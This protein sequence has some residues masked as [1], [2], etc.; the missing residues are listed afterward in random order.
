MKQS[1][2]KDIPRILE[3]EDHLIVKL[4]EE[5]DTPVELYICSHD[6]LSEV[7]THVLRSCTDEFLC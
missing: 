4:Q 5:M 6:P 2:L 1:F 3:G 7:L